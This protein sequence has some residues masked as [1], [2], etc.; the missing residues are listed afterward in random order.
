MSVPLEGRDERMTDL[1][2]GTLDERSRT[3]FE[4]VEGDGSAREALVHLYYPLVEYLSRRFRGRGEPLE[5]LVQV[6]SIG[7]LKAI[8]RFDPLRGVKFS[9][10]ATPT[11]IGELKRHFRDKGWA[12]RVPRRLQEIGLQLRSVIADCYQELGRSP[13][14]SEI[15]DRSG[16]TQEEVLEGMD[17]VH[18]YSVGS[19]DAPT[20]EDGADSLRKLGSEDETLELLE[21]W[22]NVGPLL[23][24][25]PQRERMI[26]YY[27]FV[28]GMTQS[29]IADRLQMSQ[30]HVSRLLSRTLR[31]L[32]EA[33][34]GTGAADA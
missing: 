23:R 28:R 25:L 21:G 4:R 26:L 29:Q 18:A 3:L 20:D 30:M 34:G 5:D 31:G 24:K 8:D 32:R 1:D 19:L 33:V 9:T 14:V 11:I 22:A 13:T 27:R 12:M 2:A 15:A 10:Y 6:A 7:L 17:S 16:L